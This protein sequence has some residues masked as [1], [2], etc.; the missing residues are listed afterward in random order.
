VFTCEITSTLE[1]K[2]YLLSMGLLK[3]ILYGFLLWMPTYLAH[4]DLNAYKSII[5]IVFNAGT[6][7]G[8]FLLGYFYEQKERSQSL[9]YAIRRHIKRYSL[10]Y[11]C[12]GLTGL[13][14]VFY[15]IEAEIVAY[16]VLSTFC[17]A[18][19]GGAFNMLASN[20]VISIVGGRKEEVSMLSTLSM[21]CGNLMV[22]VVEIIIGVVL[23]L[24]DDA[25]G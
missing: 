20:E 5:P 12:I 19:L 8:S 17:G 10:F 9:G 1:N 4:H 23:D 15:L 18:F 14:V 3:S 24:K 22:G 21:V 25:E 16:F 2:L 6:L 7:L 13:L 11:C